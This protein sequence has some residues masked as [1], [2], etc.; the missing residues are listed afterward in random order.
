MQTKLI[1]TEAKALISLVFKGLFH[2]ISY[3]CFVTPHGYSVHICTFIVPRHSWRINLYLEMAGHSGVELN[4]LALKTC[5][6]IKLM[7]YVFPK[8]QSVSQSLDEPAEYSNW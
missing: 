1:A 2:F 3:V 4:N 8:V 6:N 5:L 7:P